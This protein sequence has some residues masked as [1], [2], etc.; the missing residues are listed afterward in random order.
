MDDIQMVIDSIREFF[1]HATLFQEMTVADWA[2]FTVAVLIVV[3]FSILV[4]MIQMI[5]FWWKDR[6]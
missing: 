2:N 4:G 3:S 1:S 6:R 5:I